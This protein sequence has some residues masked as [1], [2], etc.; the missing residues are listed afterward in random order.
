MNAKHQPAAVNP[1]DFVDGRDEM[2]LIEFPLSSVADRF[3]DG[4][5]TVV[6]SDRVW[7]RDRRQHVARELAISGSDRYGLPTAKDEDVLLG[8]LQLTRMADF[9]SR[10]VQFSRYELLK[11]LRWPD[12]S[13]YYQR[14]ANSLRR[15]K[16]VT[17]FSDR[18]FY[19]H[20][21]KSWVNRDFGVFDNLYFYEREA[22]TKLS[23]PA[24][25]WFT[26][27]EVFFDSFQAGYLK[28]LDW[29]LYC[30]LTDPVAKRLYRLLDK[31]FYHDHEVV[32]DLQDLAV[33]KIRVSPNYNT[34]QIK[35][36]L[37][38][39]IRELE[40]V[41]ELR[42]LP[43]GR[44]FV[45]NEQGRWQ[46]LFQRQ[47][48]RATVRETA[49]AVANESELEV[50][51]SRRQIGPSMADE[52]VSGHS[53]DTVRSMIELFDW[54]NSKGQTKGAGFLVASIRNSADYAF[55][56]GFESSVQRAARKSAAR[57]REQ[58]QQQKRLARERHQHASDNARLEPFM[59]FWSGLSDEART[60]F[61]IRALTASDSLKRNGYHRLRETGGPA[62]EQYRQVILRDYFEKT[63]PT[64]SA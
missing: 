47:T 25:S 14:L 22:A 48:H 31:R 44:R 35:R 33:R 61:E 57:E 50:Q 63:K 30:Q 60:E 39:G 37:A 53:A 38:N 11:L 49:K 9:R 10:E 13:K 43:T 21:R 56:P 42:S 16:G 15:W 8:C 36:A 18:A 58:V 6:F 41:W 54:Y 17:L 52:L 2:N 5:K 23:V 1:T 32:F 27:N 45:K 7:D 51:L 40:T 24:R 34:A 64:Q 29:A 12:E 20:G 28:K 19:D 59:D 26:W 46:V 4:R 55:P 62:F 3:L